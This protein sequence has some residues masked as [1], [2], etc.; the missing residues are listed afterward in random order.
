[1]RPT[2]PMTA[3]DHDAH[4]APLRL[5]S[6]RIV[7][8]GAV[9]DGEI[10][11][12]AGRIASLDP[13]GADGVQRSPGQTIEL[14]SDWV[15]PGFIDG[16]VH[17]GGGAQCNSD[18]PD[19]VA[20]VA[21]FHARHGT[22]ALLAT[23]V[24]AP[25][26]GLA[27]A[28]RT[29]G[30][31][32]ARENGAT[33][34]GDVPGPGST[35]GAAILGVHLEGPFLNVSRPGAMDPGSFLAP[36]SAALAALLAVEPGLVAMMTVAPELPGATALIR[37]L[38]A[39]GVVASLGH[40]QATEAQTAAAVDAGACAVTH[41]FNAIGPMHHREPGLAGAALDRPGLSC[42]LIAD[43]IH[44]TASALR[45]AHRA[46]GTSGIRLVTDAIAAAGMPDGHYRLGAI[47]VRVDDG[48]ARL[49]AGQ[50][51]AGSTLTMDKA[52]QIAVRELRVEL[53]EAV[54]MASGNPARLLGLSGRKG[55]IATG[56][57]ADLAMLRED[58]S[59]RAT[60]VG[61]RWAVT[62]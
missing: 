24:S 42:E 50:A 7:T 57:D 27:A 22:T 34:G 41:T 2:V 4:H 10:V 58:L 5:R 52:V 47:E 30:H 8:P 16:H 38:A 3:V 44:V 14:G 25:L 17:G 1:M 59:M 19:E 48:C 12:R 40:S 36:D 15:V 49:A 31:A 20:A 43:G 11:V 45:L 56:M 37:E 60:L 13:A 39:R 9:I 32:R 51:L 62:P 55:S 28:L 61:G 35:P 23:T 54:M 26:S 46:K 21:A 6:R 53:P 18:D 33:A 29:I